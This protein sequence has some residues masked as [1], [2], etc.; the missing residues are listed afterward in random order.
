[1]KSQ[2]KNLIFTSLR[3]R[4]I[5]LVLLVIVPMLSLIVYHGIEE[6]SKD[7]LEALNDA[8]RLARNASMI[9][10]EYSCGDTP[11]SFHS[12]ST[13]SIPTAK[14]GRMFKDL[15]QSA[16]TDWNL[17]WF[18][19]H[20]AEWRGICLSSP[21]YKTDQYCRPSMVPTS[22]A[23]PPFCSR[24]IFNRPSHRQTYRYFGLSSPWPY[25]P[26][27]DCLDCR[28]WPGAPATNAS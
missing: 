12:F 25:R 7:R 14:S 8:R 19:C 4:L 11:D 2:V 26:A 10:W 21:L 18:S 13:E 28:T 20:Q 17:L 9:L 5:L 6:R 15:C 23:K 1:M 24:R 3:A 16:K 27:N 22:C